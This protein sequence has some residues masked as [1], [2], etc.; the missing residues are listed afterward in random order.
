MN[1]APSRP[2]CPG[3]KWKPALAHGAIKTQMAYTLALAAPGLA[4]AQEWQVTATITASPL[5]QTSVDHLNVQ[6]PL[7]C[8][9]LPSTI[10]DQVLN[11]DW[12]KDSRVVR[13]KLADKLTGP[14]T[15]P[16]KA[17]YTKPVVGSVGQAASLPLPWPLDNPR[18]GGG[19]IDVTV[20][21]EVELL[22]PR[23]WNRTSRGPQTQLAL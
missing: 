14:V 23:M 11:A 18:D 9:Y 20:P 16:V 17:R 7:D 2:I 8:E 12:D 1:T 6:L 19:R 13:I 5:F 4:G 22:G 21:N 3:W 10:P 15:V